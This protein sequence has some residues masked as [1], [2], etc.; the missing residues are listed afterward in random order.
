MRLHNL[1][2]LLSLANSQSKPIPWAVR[3]LWIGQIVAV[4]S[5]AHAKGLLIGALNDNRINIRADGTAILD[6]S[7]SASRNLPTQRDHLP[8]EL[9]RMNFDTC[10]YLDLPNGHL[11]AWFFNLAD[12]GRPA[13][14]LGLLLHQGSVYKCPSLPLRG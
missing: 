1:R 12:C 10:T 8:P 14:F 5:N 6:L 7:E 4:M 13:G 3:E 2:L 9:Q 11:P